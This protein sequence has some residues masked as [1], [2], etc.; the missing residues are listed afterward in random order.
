MKRV[1]KAVAKKLGVEVRRSPKR[2]DLPPAEKKPEPFGG[3][4][5][6][7]PPSANFDNI[8][9]VLH[10]F[11]QAKPGSVFVQVG[12]NDGETSDSVHRFVKLGT[13][14][15]VLIEPMPATFAK[16]RAFY[17]GIN[18][19]DL[20][21]AAIAPTVGVA[22]IHSVYDRGR[23]LGNTWATQLA[24]FDREHLLRHGILEDEIESSEV[25]CLD[26][27]TLLRRQGLDRI[28]VLQVD[29]EGYDAEV[30]RMALELPTPP[31][32]ICFEF[33]QFVKSMD[34]RAVNSF[35]DQLRSKGYAWSHDRL[36]TMAVHQDFVISGE[37][38]PQDR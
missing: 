8:A 34:Q 25:E 7:W 9:L 3:K 36:N 18:G 33:V 15:S 13:M 27:A 17:A 19:V 5:L 16:L 14:R 37:P 38:A 32:V 29:V 6:A 11:T 12:A 21:Q 1:L 10:Y 23:W 31:L 22:T 2:V 20:V 30:V 24:S 35:Y 28:D 4:V 26:F